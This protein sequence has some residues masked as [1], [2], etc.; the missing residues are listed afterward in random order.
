M[1][2]RKSQ[3]KRVVNEGVVTL[4]GG[5]L[6]RDRERDFPHFPLLEGHNYGQ[7]VGVDPVGSKPG[8]EEVM[9]RILPG[10]LT[11]LTGW[12]ANVHGLIGG[13][14]ALPAWTGAVPTLDQ[15]KPPQSAPNYAQASPSWTGTRDTFD[16]PR[17]IPSPAPTH[18]PGD[19]AT[20]AILSWTGT[21]P[22][23]ELP[24]QPNRPTYT[25]PRPKS[26]PQPKPRYRPKPQYR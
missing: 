23:F 15:S 11:L 3:R 12:V 25:Q 7:A 17:R 22:T 21:G 26:Q 1:G 20:R 10:V 2:H 18:R 19:R 16:R 8:L 4:A 13:A 5:A 6:V 14:A 9:A 24:A